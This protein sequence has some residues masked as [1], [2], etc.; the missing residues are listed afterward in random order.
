[1]EV[2]LIPDIY[3][4]MSSSY[5]TIDTFATW[6]EDLEVHFNNTKTDFPTSKFQYIMKRLTDYKPNT[7]IPQVN[8][9]FYI[10]TE[11]ILNMVASQ[12]TPMKTAKSYVGQIRNKWKKLTSS[13]KEI[14][15]IQTFDESTIVQYYSE[16][17]QLKKLI[18]EHHKIYTQLQKQQ[19]EC[20]I[21]NSKVTKYE[22]C[23]LTVKQ[24]R[25]F[26]N[27]KLP[28]KELTKRD[29]AIDQLQ[30][31]LNIKLKKAADASSLYRSY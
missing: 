18:N 27:D 3:R 12:Q 23:L 9:L 20:W 11:T 26:M 30:N 7:V 14:R 6:C 8:R 29:K 17:K 28:T 16:T 25:S 21:A 13:A 15:P 31:I 22:L 4:V 2:V 5:Q 10:L 1:M 19:E 24:S